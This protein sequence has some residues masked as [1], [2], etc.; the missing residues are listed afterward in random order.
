MHIPPW[1]NWKPPFVIPCYRQKCTPWSQVVIPK[2]VKHPAPECSDCIL[3]EPATLVFS[4]RSFGY[5]AQVRATL[6]AA[7]LI[8]T[9]CGYVGGPLT[10]L[11]NVPAQVTDLSTVQLDP[12]SLFFDGAGQFATARF[13]ERIN[14][15]VD[16]VRRAH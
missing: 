8:L 10:P 1:H 9:G 7:V 14:A 5:R 3:V 13:V 2:S 11:A 4:M 12:D 16:E 6:A 15:A